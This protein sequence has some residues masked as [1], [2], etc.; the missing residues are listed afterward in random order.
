MDRH[1]HF[2]REIRNRGFTLVEIMAVMLLIGTIMGIAT[3]GI[4]G[5]V[6]SARIT[7]ATTQIS[8]LGQVI[9]T[10]HLECGFYPDSL[11]SLIRPPSAGR[12]CKGFP[13]EGFLGK[14]ELPQDPWGNPY[15]FQ[16]PG[17]HD[18]S[19]YDLWSNGPDGNEGTEDDIVSWVVEKS[20][21]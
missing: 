8:S 4:M 18:T 20:G 14:K 1:R 7:A 5:R 6:K 3:V 21:G 10:F 12:T 15:N 2:N 17:V 19:S 13:P 9:T 16:A 11:E